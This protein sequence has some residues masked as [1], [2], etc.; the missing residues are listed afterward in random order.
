MQGVAGFNKM[1][2]TKGHSHGLDAQENKQ[3]LEDVIAKKLGV[4]KGSEVEERKFHK[5]SS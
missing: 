4:R 1:R 3:G 5:E 2:W